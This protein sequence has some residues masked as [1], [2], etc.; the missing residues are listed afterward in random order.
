MANEYNSPG[1]IGDDGNMMDNTVVPKRFDR[2]GNPIIKVNRALIKDETPNKNKR[3][4]KEDKKKTFR[5]TFVD[6]VE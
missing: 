6:K 3:D 1:G 5:V 4:R 2:Y